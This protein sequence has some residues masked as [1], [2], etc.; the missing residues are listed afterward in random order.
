[1]EEIRSSPP[2]A[3]SNTMRK[4][5]TSATSR[6]KK[7]CLWFAASM[8]EGF[9]YAK[10]GFIGLVYISTLFSLRSRSVMH[11]SID[12]SSITTSCSNAFS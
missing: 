1:M 8:Q 2:P 11:F 7:D 6:M 12:R 10:A 4:Q 5:E 9:G 3:A